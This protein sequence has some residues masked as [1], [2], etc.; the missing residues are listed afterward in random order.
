M[1]G[2]KMLADHLIEQS[3]VQTVAKLS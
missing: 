1:Q 2:A 3:S